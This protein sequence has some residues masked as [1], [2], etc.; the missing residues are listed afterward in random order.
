V[1]LLFVMVMNL[2]RIVIYVSEASDMEPAVLKTIHL[3]MVMVIMVLEIF[4]V[5]VME[6]EEY[7]D[8][9]YLLVMTR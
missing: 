8:V 9:D 3:E 7:N 4:L 2:F 6:V 5:M 1:V